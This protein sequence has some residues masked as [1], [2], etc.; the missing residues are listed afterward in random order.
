MW[1]VIITNRSIKDHFGPFET[2]MDALDFYNKMPKYDWD[3]KFLKSIWE[4]KDATE[5]MSKPN[6]LEIENV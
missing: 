4:L 3:K 2:Y 6:T 5:L 1:I